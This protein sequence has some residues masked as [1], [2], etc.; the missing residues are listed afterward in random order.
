MNTVQDA[1]GAEVLTQI[2]TPQG[3]TNIPQGDT[4]PVIRTNENEDGSESIVGI[5]E[6]PELSSDDSFTRKKKGKKRILKKVGSKVKK[7][8]GKKKKPQSVGDATLSFV[9]PL[10][11]AMKIGLI[12]KGYNVSRLSRQAVV[13]K[14]FNEFVSKKGDPHSTLE[15]LADGW[16]ENHY[17]FKADFDTFDSDNIGSI[18]DIQTAA[19]VGKQVLGKIKGFLAK[20][21][22][23]KAAK[24]NPKVVV[25]QS[26]N[27][28]AIEAEKAIEKAKAEKDMTQTVT[29]E[30]SKKSMTK[31][32]VFAVVGVVALFLAFKYFKK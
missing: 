26:E 16:L 19:N 20:R 1:S 24:K 21:K 2:Q 5:S 31:Y 18:G 11:K 17:L 32:I 22:A 6:T 4:P 10:I 14:F 15:P 27:Q 9:Y 13:E 12:N 8:V 29:K 3:V 23:A 7:A 25:P 30:E 28:V